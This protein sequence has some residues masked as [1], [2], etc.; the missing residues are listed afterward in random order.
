M[1]GLLSFE[2]YRDACAIEL[3][4][5]VILTGGEG[6]PSLSRVQEY[7]LW[8]FIKRLPDLITGRHEH[9]CGYYLHQGQIVSIGITEIMHTHN[10]T[11]SLYL[12]SLKNILSAGV[13]R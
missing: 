7:N 12:Y 8:G 9:S 3:P 13:Y 6:F 5:T 10:S 1:W 11:F 4:D 2:N